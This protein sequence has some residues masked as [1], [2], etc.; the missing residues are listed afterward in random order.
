VTARRQLSALHDA[1]AKMADANVVDAQAAR[2]KTDE[3]R[4][5]TDGC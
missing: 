1:R 4:M 3:D 5:I 2:T